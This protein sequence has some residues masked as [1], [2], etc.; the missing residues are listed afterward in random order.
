MTTERKI[1]NIVKIEYSH[2]VWKSNKTGRWTLK[3]QSLET[4]KK[5]IRIKRSTMNESYELKQLARSSINS[6]D[7]PYEE[8]VFDLG[9]PSVMDIIPPREMY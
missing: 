3:P 8:K 1:Q 7:R 9:R 5:R 6:R 4:R 2:K